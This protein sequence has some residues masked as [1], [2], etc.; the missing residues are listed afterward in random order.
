MLLTPKWIESDYC[1]KE[2]TIFEEV[3]ASHAVGE[4]VAPI[5]ARPIDQ[6]MQHLSSEQRDMIGSIRQRQ[7]FEAPA[8]DFL[9]LPSTRRDA[10]IEKIADDIAGMIE[11][12]RLPPQ[13]VLPNTVR[14][15]RDFAR[16]AEF[17]GRA[18]P[19]ADVDYLK[20]TSEVQVEAARE[21]R[22]R[23]V[24]AQV[25]FVER[26][27]V[28]TDNAYAEFGVSSAYLSVA[29]AAPGQLRTSNEFSA[30]D[31]RRAAYRIHREAPDALTIGMF[32][33]PGRGL[34]EIALP[35]T[36]GNFWSRI[37]TAAPAV[38]TDQ[39]RAELRVSFSPQGLQV[40]NDGSSAQSPAKT[41]KIEAILKI[42]IEK[43]ERIGAGG[44]ICRELPIRE[45]SE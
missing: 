33:D 13:P 39:L 43:Q 9:K 19:Y 12:L 32:A 1:R 24:Y 38:Q 2:Y 36:E 27:F 10:E 14:R 45:R 8:T 23:S 16:P 15:Q 26:L 41:R 7:Y 30:R 11:R 25:E 34:A 22:Q 21:G 5:L 37:G 31:P 4:Y 35:P 18:E 29:G 3:E 40:Y 44:R 17:G 28:R 6:Q 20:P 42:A